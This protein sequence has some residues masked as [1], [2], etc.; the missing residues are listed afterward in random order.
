MTRE[1]IDLGDLGLGEVLLESVDIHIE[2]MDKDVVWLGISRTGNP[3][4]RLAL[5]LSAQGRTLLA[6]VADNEI[7]V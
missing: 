6:S 5:T 1:R 4:K 2:R 3:E 7:Q